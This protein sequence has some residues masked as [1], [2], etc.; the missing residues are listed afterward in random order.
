MKKSIFSLFFTL[1]SLFMLA[2]SPSFEWAKHIGG[3]AGTYGQSMTIGLDGNIYISGYFRNSTD[4]DPGSLVYGLTAS[5]PSG[6]LFIVKLN[7]NGEFIWAKNISTNQTLDPS[8]ADVGY[9]ISLDKNN[10]VYITGSFRFTTDFDPSVGTFN[11]TSN[12]GLDVFILKLN[13]DGNFIWAKQIGGSL[14]DKGFSISVNPQNDLIAA[15]SFQDTVDFNPGIGI[16]NFISG[17]NNDAFIIKLDDLGNYI[18][19]KQFGNSVLGSA[20][21]NSVVADSIGNVFS[22]G[23]FFGAV[24]FDPGSGTFNLGSLVNVF[25]SKLDSSGDFLWAVGIGGGSYDDGKSIK[26]DHSGNIYATGYFTGMVDFDPSSTST[27]TLN[28]SNPDVFIIKL[29]PLGNFYWAKNMGLNSDAKGYDLALDMQDNVYITGQFTGISNFDP[30]VSNFT[31]SSKGST[32]IFI[33]KLNFDGNFVWAKSI[34]SS[35]DDAGRSIAIDGLNNIYTTGW[36]RNLADFDPD[37]G[38]FNMPV[39]GFY[40]TFI[41]KMS[42]PTVG[43]KENSFIN[44]I[45]IYPNPTAET[46]NIEIDNIVPKSTLYFEIS[47]ILGQIIITKPI[48]N[49]YSSFNIEQLKSGLYIVRIISKDKTLITKKIIK[50]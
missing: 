32:D 3:T 49:Q 31:L 24:D 10:N 50:N 5:S 29:D 48:F 30:S 22:T 23:S 13:S 6:D 47:N 35:T 7:Q 8:M 40:D 46:I 41:H 44:N 18:W 33:S 45:V 27:F 4:F 39:A 15:G 19:A 21:I 9:T 36:Y 12:G 38:V 28:S 11:L 37:E 42:Q 2:Q 25:I 16:H 1:T 34:G 20:Q 26:T 14:N 17:G 43:I